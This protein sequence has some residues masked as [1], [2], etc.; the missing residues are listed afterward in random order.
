MSS[1]LIIFIA[2]I[3]IV[4]LFIFIVKLKK[5][6]SK[7]N[8]LYSDDDS[9][10]LFEVE[11]LTDTEKSPDEKTEQVIK[12]ALERIENVSYELFDKIYV[13]II[14]GG[15]KPVR[16]LVLAHSGFYLFR[17][18]EKNGW[19]VGDENSRWWTQ[20]T[21]P[22]NKEIFDNPF[23]EM[24]QDIK[25]LMRFFPKT[26][27]TF[28]QTY[29]IV[30][31]QCEIRSVTMQNEDHAHILQLNEFG[32]ELAHD[33]SDSDPIFSD[34]MLVQ[35]SRVLTVMKNGDNL[36]K[37]LIELKDIMKADNERKQRIREQKNQEAVTLRRLEEMKI[38]SARTKVY[39]TVQAQYTASEKSLR[40]SLILW[41]KQQASAEHTNEQTILSDETID[42][43]SKTMPRNSDQLRRIPG[44]DND[45]VDRYGSAIV[46]MIKHN[47]N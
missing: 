22:E 30:N 4:I 46:N 44:I 14:D 43:I 27:K 23:L 34:D 32:A 31:D 38:D 16:L 12:R 5:T 21:S 3:A 26:E 7:K 8:D 19:I 11:I 17:Y 24:D 29:V 25:A 6:S 33:L 9:D 20:F 10:S 36:E 37:R 18:I 35:F 15:K 13:P 40:N 2:V 47:P 1:N 41:R 39:S 45:K 42:V 28:F